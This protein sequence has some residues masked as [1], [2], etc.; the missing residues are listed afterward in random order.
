MTSNC[1]GAVQSALGFEIGGVGGFGSVE[2]ADIGRLPID[3]NIG[4]PFSA[5]GPCPNTEIAGCVGFPR[6][7]LVLRV[8]GIG[9]ITKVANPVVV[10]NPICMVDEVL[11]PLAMHVQPCKPV[12][13]VGSGVNLCNQVTVGV[14]RADSA[15]D[16]RHLASGLPGKYAGFRVVGEKLAHAFCGKRVSRPSDWLRFV[17]KVKKVI[18]PVVTVQPVPVADP[19]LGPL[20]MSVEPRKPVSVI[21]NA[22]NCDVN[23]ASVASRPGDGAYWLA[24]TAYKPR[25]Q[26]SQ[27]IVMKQLFEPFLREGM[28]QISHAV[29]PVKKWFGQRPRCVSSTSGL[30]H[31]TIGAA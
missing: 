3:L 22:V 29:S 31:F 13:K 28:I 14:W 25:K 11:W 26:T 27:G 10:T 17:G 16:V 4:L 9:H 15:T 30:R 18:Q 19:A 7:P 12:H 8:L 2:K 21:R 6:P 20:P 24:A 5:G 1:A 23:V